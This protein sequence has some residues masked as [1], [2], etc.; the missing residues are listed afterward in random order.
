MR[1]KAI[2]FVLF[3]MSLFLGSCYAELWVEDDFVAETPWQTAD[4]LESYDLWYVDIHQTRGQG[5]VPFLQMAFT[6]SFDR[7][8]LRA[9]N[10][11]VGIGKTGGGLGVAVGS[12]APLSG[13]VEVVHQL[14]GLWELE[15]YVEGPNAIELYDPLSDTSYYLR[16]Y[17]RHLFDYDSLFYDNIHYFLQEYAA[18]E[19]IAVHT[20]GRSNA[21]DQERYLAFFAS[22]G[23]DAFRSS[24][25]PGGLPLG[26]IYWDYQGA[27]QIYD[28]P[29]EPEM[30]TITL[31]Y[32]GLGDDYFELYVADDATV[33]LYHPDSGTLYVFG[34]RGYQAYL[35]D[36]AGA[37][38]KR[39][40]R[41][42]SSMSVARRRPL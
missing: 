4:V 22:A 10:N 9:N 35:K 36:G 1:T 39:E 26:D 42:L 14:D 27:Y 15:V 24:T 37:G 40:A 6:L 25:D 13:A 12:Y 31:E 38:T 21:F 23:R 19:R 28:V 32:Q 20:E 29:G 7:G 41:K 33:E 5:E 18:W 11:L 2:P 30:K 34:G 16:G 17:D 8:V 3:V